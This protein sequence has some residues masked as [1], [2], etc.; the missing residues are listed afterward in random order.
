MS[1]TNDNSGNNSKFPQSMPL[2][3]KALQEFEKDEEQKK[4]ANRQKEFNEK[5]VNQLRER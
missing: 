2:T 4:I 1:N 5:V 3:T